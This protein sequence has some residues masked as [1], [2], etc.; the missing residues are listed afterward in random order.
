MSARSGVARCSSRRPWSC[1][2][3]V[4]RRWRRK[5][6]FE[7]RRS[8]YPPPSRRSFCLAAVAL[9]G[10][11]RAG[12]RLVEPLQLSCRLAALLV[13]A[14]FSPCRVTTGE[15]VGVARTAKDPENSTQGAKQVS[16]LWPRGLPLLEL[17]PTHLATTGKPRITLCGATDPLAPAHSLAYGV[18]P[19]VS[20]L[21]PFDG[22]NSGAHL[23]C[24]G[25]V[26]GALLVGERLQPCLAA[27]PQR[28]QTAAHSSA[29]TRTNALT[30]NAKPALFIA[31]AAFLRTIGAR[32]PDGRVRPDAIA[33]AFVRSATLRA[34]HA[35]RRAG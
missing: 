28:R 10:C 8:G 33:S 22:C 26:V 24:I 7:R 21:Q 13:P 18:A 17:A 2:P 12:C 27:F 31:A 35:S 9:E 16:G 20:A 3:S 1:L 30:L 29:R 34:R 5:P 14:S 15:R 25:R 11:A 23:I 6:P 32:P 4:A 19:N